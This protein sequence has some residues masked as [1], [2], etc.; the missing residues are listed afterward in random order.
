ME[1]PIM[2][3]PISFYKNWRMHIIFVVAAAAMILLVC[4]AETLKMLIL[5]KIASAALFVLCL[6]LLRLWEDKIPEIS[7]L[8][9]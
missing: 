6:F 9:E 3:N 2:E 8:D 4:D 7:I 1:N 5:S